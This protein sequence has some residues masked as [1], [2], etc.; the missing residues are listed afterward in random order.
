M[1]ALYLATGA[2]TGLT[3]GLLGVGGGLIVVP[4]LAFLFARAG[5]YPDHLMHV[6]LGTSLATIIVTS[7][8]S[9]LAH[10]R[11]RAIRWP[12]VARIAPGL[13][14]GALAGGLLADRIATSL[15]QAGFGLFVIVVALNMLFGKTVVAGEERGRPNPGAGLM[16]GLVS[17]LTGIGGG[18]MTVPYLAWKGRPLRNAI[19]TSAACG[20]PIALAA[21]AGFVWSGRE[22]TQSVSG[23]VNATAFLAIVMVSIFT[24]PL[25]AIL[26]HRLPVAMIKKVF[27]GF[28]IVVGLR[29]LWM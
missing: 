18:S 23:Y 21:T 22:V 12:D 15:L 8:A 13:A 14:I 11:H 1:I 2:L 10:Q 29:M 27:A 6:A 24:A 4:A 9:I 3:A 19:A 17:A 20:L 28:L 26:A 5:L 7:V 16:I 25:G